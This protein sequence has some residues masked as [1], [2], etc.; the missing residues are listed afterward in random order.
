MIDGAQV[1]DVLPEL[2]LLLGLALAFLALAA[3]LF[4]WE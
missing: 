3:W 2:L 1:L 4:R